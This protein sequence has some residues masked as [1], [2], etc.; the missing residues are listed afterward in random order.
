ME[1]NISYQIRP[2]TYLLFLLLMGLSTLGF[3]QS[4]SFGGLYVGS[5]GELVIFDNHSF[6]NGDG[7]FTA[8]IIG[9]E[10]QAPFGLIT[11]G[12]AAAWS[13]ASDLGFV[14]GYVRKYGTASFVF[15]VGDNGKYRP[16]KISG[17]SGASSF[18]TMSYFRASPSS[19]ITSNLAGGD[20]V[21]L[22]ADAPFSVTTKAS[23][24]SSVSGVEYWDIDA[25]EATQI[26]LSYDANSAIA[27]LTGNVLSKLTIVGW[28]T[29]TN[30]WEVIPSTVDD[31]SFL[32]GSST[33]TSGSISSI[34]SI[35]PSNYKAFTLA[36]AT[37][38]IVEVNIKAFLQGAATAPGTPSVLNTDGLMRDDLR[39]GVNAGGTNLIPSSEPYTALGFTGVSVN[40]ALTP[41]FATTGNNAI[42]DW[43]LVE[44]RSAANSTTVVARQ[45]ALIQRDGDVV[46][47][48]GVSTLR[49][50]A[51][52]DNYYI[53]L[54]HRN[55]LGVMSA[56]TLAL[57]GTGIPA[58][59][60]FSLT[61]TAT[62]GTNAQVTIGTKRLLWAGN[63][64]INSDLSANILNARVIAQG[65]M[66]DRSRV[67]RSVIND[68]NNTTR[69]NLY[70]LSKGYT[71]SD[72]NLDGK[73]V[74][75]G[76]TSDNDYIASIVQN[77]PANTSNLKI[78]I[79]K[80]QLP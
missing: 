51:A 8:G 33:L 40:P 65:S 19:A 14:D 63:A 57:S 32:G 58:S 29:S 10:R 23:S 77:H 12:S 4:G 50:F 7:A 67:L 9:T 47:I 43:V 66:S 46:D 26:S 20:H 64:N 18:A 31:T 22:P 28:S 11:F 68:T 35:I 48:D 42:V 78:F 16:A 55:H 39:T 70:A 13:S 75:T 27:A 60:D 5:G 36:S 3:G 21:A 72:I 38:S 59:I 53:A 37:T 79:I 34:F 80:Q 2:I 30:Q 76:T 44:L 25:T 1:K 17:L 69:S 54:R 71:S 24:I 73:I 15:P 56:S 62:S 74:V 45:A 52:V 61:T 41:S 6:Q 49:I